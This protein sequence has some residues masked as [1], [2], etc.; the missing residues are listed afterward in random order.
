MVE[1]LDDC[2][3]DEAVLGIGLKNCDAHDDRTGEPANGDFET[4]GNNVIEAT[5]E[6]LMT[7]HET[8][9]DARILRSGNGLIHRK[10]LNYGDKSVTNAFNMSC[11]VT[12]CADR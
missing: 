2:A 6:G 10:T 12:V 5:K 11:E 8:A 4:C 7:L 9:L 1:P 3:D